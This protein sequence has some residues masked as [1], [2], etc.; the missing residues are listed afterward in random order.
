MLLVVRKMPQV[1]QKEL[2]SLLPNHLVKPLQFIHYFDVMCD[3]EQWLPQ[4]YT[5]VAKRRGDS[6]LQTSS[7]YACALHLVVAAGHHTG[8]VTP[9][10]MISL[11]L[12]N[13]NT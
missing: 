6:T 8:M 3:H 4:R 13:I 12:C 11:G 5:P 1:V 2:C 7:T 10:A 9:N